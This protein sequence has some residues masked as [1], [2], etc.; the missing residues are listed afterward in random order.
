M[1]EK[2]FDLTRI[3]TCVPMRTSPVCYH[4]VDVPYDVSG[5]IYST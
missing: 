5:L 2:C 3:K 1:K 4:R